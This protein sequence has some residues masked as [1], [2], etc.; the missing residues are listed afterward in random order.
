LRTD[1]APE[2]RAA[3]AEAVAAVSEDPCEALEPLLSDPHPPVRAA[4]VCGLLRI[5]S[6]ECVLAA[7]PLLRAMATAGDPLERARAARILG[8]VGNPRFYRPLSALLGDP[9]KEV[10]RAACEAT[11]ELLAPEL[12]GPLLGASRKQGSRAAAAFT[13]RSFE[14]RAVPGI[15]EALAHSDTD[16][17]ARRHLAKTLGVV[18]SDQA[19]TA[20]LRR[21]SAEEDPRVRDALWKSVV[22]AVVRGGRELPRWCDLKALTRR[23]LRLLYV[24]AQ[25]FEAALESCETPLLAMASQ[26]RLALARGRVL[27]ALE[28]RYREPGIGLARKRIDAR[29][30]TARANAHEILSVVLDWEDRRAVLPFFEPTAARERLLMVGKLLDLAP[31][32]AEEAL[33]AGIRRA[34]PWMKVCALHAAAVHGVRALREA[35]EA[36]LADPVPLVREAAAMAL[37]RIGDRPLGEREV[38]MFTL[39]EKVVLLKGVGL[40]SE[41]PG[42]D[43]TALVQAAEEVS[44]APGEAIIHEGEPGDTLYAV[45]H[46]SVRVER[47]GRLLA[48]LG[49]GE[50]FGELA[51]IDQEPRSATVIAEEG[52]TLLAIAQ[53]DFHELLADHPD[54]ATSV[55]RVISRRLREA[56]KGSES[57]G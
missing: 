52:T 33:A 6:L 38:A 4:A 44:P 22:R 5:G 8:R 40:F 15:E 47:G 19:L 56:T 23:E 57:P 45:L 53:E 55:L 16:A 1:S 28:A 34:D 11:R 10:R 3:A 2:V 51:I 35:A 18:G 29:E 20:L 31:R 13:L 9:E 17:E 32:S 21:L 49:P 42:D 37:T 54:L 25:G 27:R 48:R 30:P 39:L 26:S 12:L 7:G 43:L 36:A 24:L 46:G 50:C 41:V 14:D